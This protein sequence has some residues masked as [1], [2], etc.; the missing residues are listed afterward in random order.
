M[1]IYLLA[2]P[3]YSFLLPIYSFWNQDNFTWGNTRIVVGEKGN[4]QIVAIEDEGFD[5]R[6]VPLQRWDDYAAAN[7]LPGR[8]GMNMEKAYQEDFGNNVYE[9]DDIHSVYSS[10]KPASTVLTGFHGG[11][12][13][14]M[15]PQ[16]PAAFGQPNRQQS[17]TPYRDQPQYSRPHSRLQSL[18]GLSDHY[19]DH[20][21]QRMSNLPSTDNLIAMQSPPLRQSRSPLG[22]A[23]RPVSTV[24]FRGVYNGPDDNAIVEAVRS[25]LT[26][27]DLDN[28]TKKQV[29][30]LVEQRLQTELTGDKK[31]FL[32]QQIDAELANM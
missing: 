2:F 21:Y 13:A 27:V 10:A 1:I 31:A 7:N 18:A 12:P 4:K 30:A 29:R 19:T 11:P 22:Y 16:S 5:P 15:P 26:E 25:C 17:F 6:S 32:D 20:P 24:D 9:L 8:R 3:I 23:S 14:Y 28:V